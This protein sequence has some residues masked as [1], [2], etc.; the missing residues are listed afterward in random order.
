MWVITMI[1]MPDGGN[2]K[3][4]GRVRGRKDGQESFMYLYMS[5]KRMWLVSEAWYRVDGIEVENEAGVK[6]Q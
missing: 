3:L 2:S 5:K 4:K 1:Y 6:S